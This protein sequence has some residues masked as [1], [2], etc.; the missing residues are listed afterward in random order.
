MMILGIGLVGVS[1][2]QGKV[3][4]QNTLAKQ[5]IDAVNIAEGKLE[6]L[7]N[8][9]TLNDYNT[10]LVSGNVSGGIPA[11]ANN[12]YTADYSLEWKVTEDSS[13]KF[14]TLH[15]RVQWDDMSNGGTPSKYTTFDLSTKV[16]TRRLPVSLQMANSAVLPAS[17]PEPEILKPLVCTCNASNTVDSGSSTWGGHMMKNTPSKKLDD[18]LI[19]V[20]G[21][22]MRYTPPADTTTA[23]NTL[24]NE[25]CNDATWASL[26]KGLAEPEFMYARSPRNDEWGQFQSDALIKPLLSRSINDD[27]NI[28]RVMKNGGNTSYT[29]YT[30]ACAVNVS[31]SVNRCARRIFKIQD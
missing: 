19:K 2:L 21:G 31:S 6:E 30:A 27:Y 29:T 15:V 16:S 26:D 4:K 10:K 23:N 13:K 20:G 12:N 11:D 3:V 1:Q 22:M 7:R 18:Y 28:Q 17:T 14:K 24:C 25:C 9:V 5:R 8:L